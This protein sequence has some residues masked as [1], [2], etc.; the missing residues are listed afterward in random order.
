MKVHVFIA[1]KKTTGQPT[2]QCKQKE[3]MGS[4]GCYSKRGLFQQIQCTGQRLIQCKQKEPTTP[5][6]QA[7]S[8]KLAS[9]IDLVVRA[10]D[11]LQ[12]KDNT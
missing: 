2:I 7:N 6:M 5:A 4:Y 1:L 11:L 8:V 9:Y 10:S 12:G 3:P